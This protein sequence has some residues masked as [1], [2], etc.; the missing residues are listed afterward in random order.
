MLR[1]SHC[2]GLDS[3]ALA[4]LERIS[5]YQSLKKVHINDCRVDEED[6]KAF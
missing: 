3:D 6:L 4:Y 5:S 1:L 2:K